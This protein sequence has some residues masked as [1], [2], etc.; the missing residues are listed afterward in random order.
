MSEEKFLY[1]LGRFFPKLALMVS[2][3]FK[4]FDLL[5]DTCTHGIAITHEPGF[6][7]PICP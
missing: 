3:I 1:V 5:S 7:L 4:H 6:Y 2:M